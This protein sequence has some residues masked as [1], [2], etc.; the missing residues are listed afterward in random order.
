MYCRRLLMITCGCCAGG[1]TQEINNDTNLGAATAAA[2]G[3]RPG[4]T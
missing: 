3:R 1:I 2:P 4:S